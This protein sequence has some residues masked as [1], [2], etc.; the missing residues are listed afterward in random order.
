[1]ASVVLKETSVCILD[2]Q[3]EGQAAKVIKKPKSDLAVLMSSRAI[4]GYQLPKKQHWLTSERNA[5]ITDK[6]GP[7]LWYEANIFQFS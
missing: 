7:V 5:Q 2:A 1:M 6:Q 4:D 3:S